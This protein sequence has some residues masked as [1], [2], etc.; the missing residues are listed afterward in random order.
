MS[1]AK[2]PV[3]YRGLVALLAATFTM[4]GTAH[5]QEVPAVERVAQSLVAEALAANREL[6]QS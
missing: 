3:R 1:N 2:T 6:D 4:S 5:A